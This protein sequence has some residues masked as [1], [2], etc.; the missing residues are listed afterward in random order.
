MNML[1]LNEHITIE[2]YNLKYI[3]KNAIAKANLKVAI[4]CV[5]SVGGIALPRFTESSGCKQ[6]Y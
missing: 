6:P 2:S 4:D 1:L 3:D 5:N